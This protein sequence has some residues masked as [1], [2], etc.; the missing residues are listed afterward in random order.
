MRIHLAG[1]MLLSIW[2]LR[3]L[4][5]PTQYEKYW[6]MVD[7]EYTK[8]SGNLKQKGGVEV[9]N[10]NIDYERVRNRALCDQSPTKRSNDAI[11]SE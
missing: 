6:P 7:T 11:A 10:T 8:L 2:K 4:Y 3:Y 5:L 1:R 9:Q